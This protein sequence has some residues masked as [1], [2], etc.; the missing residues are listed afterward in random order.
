MRGGRG[1]ISI[2]VLILFAGYA[3]FV[4]VVALSN[5]KGHGSVFWASIGVIVVL[6]VA[7]LWLARWIYRRRQA[8]PRARENA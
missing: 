3:V 5:G 4:L 2:V 1:W 8:V 7:S 6:A